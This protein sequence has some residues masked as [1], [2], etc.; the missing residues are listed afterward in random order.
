MAQKERRHFKDCV[1]C[2]K[3]FSSF[4]FPWFPNI[5]LFLRKP[6]PY[7]WVTL[8]LSSVE[9]GFQK[10]KPWWKRLT[11]TVIRTQIRVFDWDLSCSSA[12]YRLCER[13]SFTR[14][15]N[16]HETN[17]PHVRQLLQVCK[18]AIQ[19]PEV[20]HSSAGPR[21]IIIVT[22]LMEDT[23]GPANSPIVE[24][25]HQ[26]SRGRNGTESWADRQA[27]TTLFTLGRQR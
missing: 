26:E 3:L 22:T 15:Y 19:C 27:Y 10:P 4:S 1:D 23:W 13:L 20:M 17:I 12:I 18:S 9:S 24:G 2:E 25:S 6:Y 11:M 16:G 5:Y 8:T 7:S 14:L 21:I